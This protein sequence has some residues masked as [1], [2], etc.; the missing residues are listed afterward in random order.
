MKKL[1]GI[2]IAVLI[3]VGLLAVRAKR[4]EQ[5]DSAPLVRRPVPV[6]ETVPV[7]RETVSR[8]RHV[9]G[10][11]I[12]W[13]EAAVSPRIM[14]R[15]LEVRVRE[16]DHVRPGQVLAV[17]DAREL[18]DGVAQAGAGL[19]AAEEGVAAAEAQW[20]AQREVTRRNRV[21]HEAGALS[22]E[23]WEASTAA[24]RS[25]QARLEAARAE[26]TVARK[27][28]DQARTRKGYAVLSAPF[29]GRVTGRFADPG[30]LAV[31][32]KPVVVVARN[33]RMKV[34]AELPV[35]DLSV[36]AVGDG[37]T[38]TLGGESVEAPVSRV[39]PAAGVAGLAVF[40]VDIDRA[41][42]TFVPGA[43]VGVD[44]VLNQFEGPAVPLEAL[45]EGEDGVWIFVVR[46]ISEGSN[47]GPTT[48]TIDPIGVEILGRSA[49]LAVIDGDVEAGDPVVV[50]RPARLMTL[51]DAMTVEIAGDGDERGTV[52]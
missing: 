4:I 51:A 38:V 26:L 48:G 11:I 28:H 12:A 18:E 16:G 41:P 44:V 32:G 19:A 36:L 27:R 37:V 21:L 47:G 13:E 24:E 9:T 39:V 35:E 43:T 22:D 40:E 15:V 10:K 7:T 23:Q 25:V 8:S 31:Q 14:A 30:D 2:I 17:L 1:S 6:V 49:D 5:R 34:R 46:N 29:D 50:A 3:A 33:G 45:L 52:R 20:E 42:E